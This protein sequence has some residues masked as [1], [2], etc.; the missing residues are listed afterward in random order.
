MNYQSTWE[1]RLS[2][3]FAGK[4]QAL[5]FRGLRLAA[6]IRPRTGFSLFSIA[7][8]STYVVTS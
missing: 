4:L 8:A 6:I 7:E 3:G 2:A 5:S 1:I